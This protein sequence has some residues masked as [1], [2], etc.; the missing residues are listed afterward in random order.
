MLSPC[1]PSE[2]RRVL[3]TARFVIVGKNHNHR[4][5]CAIARITQIRLF[6]GTVRCPPFTPPSRLP[7]HPACLERNMGVCLTPRQ[8]CVVTP[9]ARFGPPCC[10]HAPKPTKHGNGRKYSAGIISAVSQLSPIGWN[11]QPA[12]LQIEGIAFEWY[13]CYPTARAVSPGHQTSSLVKPRH[14][15][16]LANSLSQTGDML[17]CACN[18]GPSCPAERVGWWGRGAHRPM[19]PCGAWLQCKSAFPSVVDV[20]GAVAHSVRHPLG[21]HSLGR[22]SLPTATRDLSGRTSSCY[23]DASPP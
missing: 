11:L 9:Q 5:N 18:R 17:A 7:M 8:I 21:R 13:V 1:T 10:A 19:S 15:A 6:S 14:Y 2:I 3:C 12:R 16:R 23:E 22:R 20:I 4:N